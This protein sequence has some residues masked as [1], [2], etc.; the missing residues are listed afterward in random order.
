MAEK[1]EHKE[2]EHASEEKQIG[3]PF[4]PDFEDN[5]GLRTVDAGLP[6]NQILAQIEEQDS[7]RILRK[8]DLRLVPLLSFLYL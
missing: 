1:S 3:I 5:D 6:T 7:R 2:L 8:I 4:S